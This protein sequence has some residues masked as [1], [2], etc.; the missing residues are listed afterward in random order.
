MV[1]TFNLIIRDAALACVMEIQHAVDGQ[2]EISALHQL[3]S[4]SD[5]RP[6]LQVLELGTG[7]GF[8]GIA[9]AQMIPQCSMH[10]T[11]LEE[12]REIVGRNVDSATL[13]P[14]STVHFE[15]LDWDE[16]LSG[17]VS[18]RRHDLIVVSDCTYNAD[19][20]PALVSTLRSLSNC[21]PD[22]P[23]LIALKRRHESEEVFFGLMEEA[24]FKREG[25]NSDQKDSKRNH[26]SEI[27]IYCFRG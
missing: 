20:M 18:S 14:G 2:C 19:S 5:A 9:M 15:V 22:C 13:A 3:L 24:G 11:D 10:I 12:A 27:E 6:A 17:E 4:N 23:V 16:E 1:R 25:L 21:S 7:S 26:G 8:V